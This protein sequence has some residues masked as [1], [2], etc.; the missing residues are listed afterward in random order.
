[1]SIKNLKNYSRKVIEIK[2]ELWY[3]GATKAARQRLESHAKKNLT[4]MF[5]GGEYIPKS[6]PLHKPGRYPTFEAAWSHED[7]DKINEGDVYIISN[8]AWPEWYKV[9]K[10]IS[11]ADRC[12][13]YQTSSPFRDYKVE[14]SEHFANQHDAETYIHNTLQSKGIEFLNEWFRTDLETIINVIKEVDC[15]KISARHR[16]EHHPQYDLGLCD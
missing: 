15:E 6:H 14:Y 11:A 4:R 10:A 2:G 9:G 5:V 16:D 12:R 8:P 3:A 1:M 7:L 13:G